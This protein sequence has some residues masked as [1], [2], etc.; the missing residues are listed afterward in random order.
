MV[1]FLSMNERNVDNNLPFKLSDGE[2]LITEVKRSLLPYILYIGFSLTV[3]GAFLISAIQ[4]YGQRGS[5]IGGLLGQDMAVE[6][7][8]MLAWVFLAVAVLTLFFGLVL[9]YVYSLNRMFIT[10][11][12][13]VRVLYYTPFARDIKVISHLNI[14]DVKEERG[15]VG[16]IFGYGSLT[17]ST[18]GQNATYQISYVKNASDYVVLATDTRD[19]Y[20]KNLVDKGGGGVIPG[21]EKR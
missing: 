1:N 9:A 15:F 14:E 19:E 6:T 8:S 12:H 3:A 21:I 13:V 17:L 4:L 16:F 10:N 18:E 5:W 2:E 11:E 20:E 7:S